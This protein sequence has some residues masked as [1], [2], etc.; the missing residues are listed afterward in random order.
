MT[1]GAPKAPPRVGDA[2]GEGGDA[3]LV[4]STKAV[5][6][7][8]VLLLAQQGCEGEEVI[9]ILHYI[10]NSK[11]PCRR[12]SG[13]MRKVSWQEQHNTQRRAVFAM[14]DEALV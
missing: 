6:V 9:L 11:A 3:F 8:V 10:N 13:V 2:T 7:T 4:A 14:M 12:T 5:I 1:L